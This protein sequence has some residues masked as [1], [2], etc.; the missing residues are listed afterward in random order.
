M[1]EASLSAFV[2]NLGNYNELA[3]VGDWLE[4]PTDT[5]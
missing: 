1:S 2:T 3:L 4:L 5:E